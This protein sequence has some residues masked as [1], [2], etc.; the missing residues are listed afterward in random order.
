M[1]LI[2][3]ADKDLYNTKD[4]ILL[5]D[6]TTFARYN[7]KV[8]LNVDSW[9]TV[10][11]NYASEIIPFKEFMEAQE[12]L[13]KSYPLFQYECVSCSKSLKKIRFE[14][15]PHFDDSDYPEII[16]YVAY[17]FKDKDI[18]FVE[19]NTTQMLLHKWLLVKDDYTGF[20][21]Q[22]SYERSKEKYENI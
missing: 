7:D 17:D 22:E 11:K 18:E 10:Q 12:A 16:N 8:G 4:P 5:G 14:N 2:K 19:T 20:N 21:V 15:C 6:G 1:Q 3:R 9:V 13:N